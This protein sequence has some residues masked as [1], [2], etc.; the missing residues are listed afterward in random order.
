MWET[1]SRADA[2]T[3]NKVRRWSTRDQADQWEIWISH[4]YRHLAHWTP[5]LISFNVYVYGKCSCVMCVHMCVWVHGVW[6]AHYIYGSTCR[7]LKLITPYLFIKSVSLSWTQNLEMGVAGLADLI[8]GSLV[9][10]FWALASQV[11]F[12]W[13]LGIQTLVFGLMW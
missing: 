1:Q 5:P 12:T 9:S 2:E 7:G 11:A 10:T 8:W 4:M 6:G 13:V 3:R